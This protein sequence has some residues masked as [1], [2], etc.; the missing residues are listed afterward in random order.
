MKK[1]DSNGD[2]SVSDRQPETDGQSSRDNAAHQSAPSP[3][4][5]GGT[6]EHD[7]S[8]DMKK[9]KRPRS[10]QVSPSTNG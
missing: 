3:N 2:G 5:K 10:N 6:T 7:K 4:T 9:G 1:A 8:R